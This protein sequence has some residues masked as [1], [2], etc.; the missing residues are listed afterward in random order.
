M[1]IDLVQVPYDSGHRGY[2]MGAGPLAMVQSGLP[3]H[4]TGN[5]HDVRTVPVESGSEFPTEISAAFTLATRI[6]NKVTESLDQGRFPIVLAGN[7]IAALGVAASLGQVDVYWFDAHGDL[8]TPESTKSGFLD[9][10][11]L[12]ILLG[13]CW[14][15]LAAE[16]GV[17]AIPPDRVWLIGGRDLDPG[18]ADYLDRAG[19]HV[20]GSDL[21]LA[22]PPEL[23]GERHAYLHIDLDVLDPAEGTVNPFQTAGGLELG[24]LMTVIDRIR[25]RSP[26]GALALTAYDP[27][28]DPDGSIVE[29]AR[30][31]VDRVVGTGSGPSSGE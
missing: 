20:A 15:A 5:G 3:D 14:T 30:R 17:P 6:R 27:A 8:N 11:A 24:Q 1:K 31:I 4:L 7:C 13:R 28:G 23:P 26:F 18:E 16:V 25:E 21:T 22:R 2:R 9:G 12:S 19:I 29:A 10:M